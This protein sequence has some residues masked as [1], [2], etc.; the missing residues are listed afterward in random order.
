MWDKSGYGLNT[1][2]LSK[3]VFVKHTIAE[4]QMSAILKIFQLSQFVVGTANNI[5]ATVIS[6]VVFK[7]KIAFFSIW[8]SVGK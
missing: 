1:D 2:W 8:S 7:T 5:V 4:V 6:A 3:Y